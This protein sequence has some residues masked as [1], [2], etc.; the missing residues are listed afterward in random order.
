MSLGFKRLILSILNW[1]QT[2]ANSLKAS[3][4]IV[5]CGFSVKVHTKGKGAAV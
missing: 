4:A 1:E 3:A 5:P 2:L